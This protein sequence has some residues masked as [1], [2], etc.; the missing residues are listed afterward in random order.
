SLVI[1]VGLAV[2]PSSAQLGPG[3]ALAGGVLQAMSHATAKAAMFM[4]AG[5]MYAALGHDRIAGLGG[6]GRTRPLSVLAFALGGVALIGPPPSGAYLAKELLFGAAD[7]TGQWWW[8]LVMQAGGVF[9][10]S[11][12]VLVLTNA[13]GAGDIPVVSRDPA[14]RGPELAALTLAVCSLA[15]G[16]APWEAYLGIPSASL[17]SA[18]QL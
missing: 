11:Y 13:L 18:L 10:A 7:H 15:L 17:T 6:I 9:T 3:P 14:P 5:L 8:T 4:A 16:L 12:L 1:I 2:S